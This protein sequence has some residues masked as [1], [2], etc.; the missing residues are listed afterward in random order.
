MKGV[1]IINNTQFKEVSFDKNAEPI[2]DGFFVSQE[3]IPRPTKNIVATWERRVLKA[4]REERGLLP[5]MKIT[6]FWNL[7]SGEIGENLK[8]VAGSEPYNLIS[9]EALKNRFYE[10]VYFPNLNMLG[11]ATY[12]GIYSVPSDISKPCPTVIRPMGLFLFDANGECYKQDTNYDWQTGAPSGDGKKFLKARF[13]M[14]LL[15]LPICDTLSETGEI[16]DASYS[17]EAVKN[18]FPVF[19][20]SGGNRFLTWGDRLEVSEGL[21]AVKKQSAA[22]KKPAAKKGRLQERVNKLC[23]R[24]YPVRRFSMSGKIGTVEAVPGEKNMC[25]VRTFYVCEEQTLESGRYFIGE[26]EQIACT[27]D[28]RGKWTYM[29]LKKDAPKHWEFVIPDKFFD[30]EAVKPTLLG[31]SRE[32]IHSTPIAARGVALWGVLTNPWLERLYKAGFEEYVKRIFKETYRPQDAFFFDTQAKFPAPSKLTK[33]LRLNSFQTALLKEELNSVPKWLYSGSHEQYRYYHGPLAIARKALFGGFTMYGASPSEP[34]SLEAV[35]D[36]DFKKVWDFAT[37]LDRECFACEVK[38][39]VAHYKMGVIESCVEDIFAMWGTKGVK[40][41]FPTLKELYRQSFSIGSRFDPLLM[42]HEYLTIAKELENRAGLRPDMPISRISYGKVKE[43]HD[44]VVVSLGIQKS[45]VDREKW[46]ARR[47]FWEKWRFD[48]PAWEHIIIP[49]SD[50]S[51][52]FMETNVL[53][54]CVGGYLSRVTESETNIFFLRKREEPDVPFYTIQVKN[55][56][57]IWQI[58]GKENS[59]LPKTMYPFIYDW[60]DKKGTKK[61]NWDRLYG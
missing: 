10:L 34:P 1:I 47:A 52:L 15:A 17:R 13:S 58:H 6:M 2:Y 26:K 45:Q 4:E 18:I 31:F 3:V 50:P 56:G 16:L 7:T 61:S 38:E 11:V 40:K 25:V 59:N 48:D 32:I 39:T 12:N 21:R 20:K 9:R 60:I 24:K 27:V 42:Y 55:D 36:K 23:A 41:S 28:A 43:L 57:T 53:G 51:E 46:E 19:L 29:P 54:H 35:S 8:K 33:F 49:P 44:N 5:G 14:P 30:E 37:S 22:P